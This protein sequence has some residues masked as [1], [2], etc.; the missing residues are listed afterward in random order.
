MDQ[1]RQHVIPACERGHVVLIRRGV[2]RQP[3]AVHKQRY[4]FL[5]AVVIFSDIFRQSLIGFGFVPIVLDNTGGHGFHD[6]ERTVDRKFVTIVFSFPVL[7]TFFR[8]NTVTYQI[9]VIP[10]GYITKVHIVFLGEFFYFLFRK[11][12][13]WRKLT[14]SHHGIFREHI[15]GRVL[16]ILLD[17]QDTGHIGKSY[18]PVIL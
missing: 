6:R 17:R 9:A 4:R 16:P 2:D 10:V 8:R 13:V 18:M 11:T 3:P 5:Q 14:R 1:E 15:Q 7:L 12:G